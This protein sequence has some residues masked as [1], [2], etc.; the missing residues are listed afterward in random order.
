MIVVYL[1]SSKYISKESLKKRAKKG[2]KRKGKHHVDSDEEITVV[3][4][5]S[6]KLPYE[7]V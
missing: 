4:T 1:D 6:G 5:G 7:L 2:K 3:D